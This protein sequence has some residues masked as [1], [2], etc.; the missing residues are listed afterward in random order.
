MDSSGAIVVGRGADGREDG[1]VTAG[2]GASGP[3][4]GAGNVLDGGGGSGRVVW[5]SSA[6]TASTYGRAPRRSTGA[7]PSSSCA[8]RSAASIATADCQRRAGSKASARS[9]SSQSASGAD[10]SSERTD[11]GGLVAA[12]IT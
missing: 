2:I 10:G 8:L 7:R 6:S 9:T 5:L 3:A 11:R 4:G 1:G 12:A